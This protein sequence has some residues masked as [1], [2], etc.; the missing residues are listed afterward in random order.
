VDS[1]DDP[2]V[3]MNL[4]DCMLAGEGI[5]FFLRTVAV[6]REAAQG[7][8]RF[9][10]INSN[11]KYDPGAGPQH[12]SFDVYRLLQTWA[13]MAHGGAYTYEHHD[14]NGFA[15]YIRVICG[16]KIWSWSRCDATTRDGAM[17]KMTNT[18][19]HRAIAALRNY[20]TVLS[21]GDILIQ[22]PNM[23]HRVYTPM[24]SICF[25]AHFY[26]L[27]SMHLTELAMKIDAQIADLATNEDHD[28]APWILQ[29]IVFWL[30]HNDEE[31]YKQSFLALARM[32][33][34]P[35]K[36]CP[37]T[38]KPKPS[39]KSKDLAGSWHGCLEAEA[40]AAKRIIR[41][42]LKYFS[43]EDIASLEGVG[44]DSDAVSTR[45]WDS[46]DGTEKVTIWKLCDWHKELKIM[47]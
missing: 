17:E 14:S 37:P 47:G 20:V 7:T 31:I 12:I 24:K 36:Y 46:I 22:P 10:S 6:D 3:C 18:L 43:A 44:K 1:A 23:I 39:K 9:N 28:D 30:V 2:D 4:L 40:N 13:I 34:N 32:I 16:A 41:H 21:P 11:F 25:G 8:S 26:S 42:C 45:N 5:P 19:T 35:E 33:L 15:T 27:A 29:R 38:S